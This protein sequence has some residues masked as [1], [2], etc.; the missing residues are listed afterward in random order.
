MLHASVLF[1]RLGVQTVRMAVAVL[2]SGLVACAARTNS[3][4]DHVD[5]DRLAQIVPGQISKDDVEQILGSPSTASIFDGETWYYISSRTETVAFLEPKIVERQVVV[6]RF[7]D[8]GVVSAV[9]AFGAERGQ[10]VKIV[11]RET[12]STGS[13]MTMVQQFFGNIGRFNKE[14]GPAQGPGQGPSRNRY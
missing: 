6:I 8:K 7:D 3:Y 5:S 2:C 13:Q 9:D 14:Q 1:R 4:G 12:P 10:E 11:N